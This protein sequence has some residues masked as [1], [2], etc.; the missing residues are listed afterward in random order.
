MCD[1]LSGGEGGREGGRK[2]SGEF[3]AFSGLSPRIHNTNSRRE[4]QREEGRPE[5]EG[6]GGNFNQFT[7]T[8]RV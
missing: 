6:R 4:K 7:H 2:Q 5:G 1:G 8:T 3:L